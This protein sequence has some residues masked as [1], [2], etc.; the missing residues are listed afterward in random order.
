MIL[1]TDTMTVLNRQGANALL[2]IC[3][4]VA[5]VSTVTS[6]S[7]VATAALSA[8]TAAIGSPD[9]RSMKCWTG[10]GACLYGRYSSNLGVSTS[11]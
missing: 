8:G 11:R 9:T 10:F 4:I 5:M 3:S 1:N 6:G 2:T 7:I